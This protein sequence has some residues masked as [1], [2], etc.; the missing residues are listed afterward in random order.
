MEDQRKIF[1]ENT[2]GFAQN[3]IRHHDQKI[4]INS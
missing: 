2:K 3:R 4:V 1:I